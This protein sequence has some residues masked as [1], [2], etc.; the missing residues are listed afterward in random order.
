MLF[1]YLLMAHLVSDYLL[2]PDNLVEWKN[3]SK[4]GLTIHAFIHFLFNTLVLYVYTG[5]LAVAA[6]ALLLAIF[7]YT[8]DLTKAIYDRKNGHHSFSYWADQLVHYVSL[9][10]VT[11]IAWRFDGVFAGR[12]IGTGNPFELMFFNPFI[13]S[14]FSLAIFITL[15]V[16]YSSGLYSKK[17]HRSFSMLDK[18]NMIKR[19]L[20]VTIVYVGLL[21]ALVPSVGL[22]F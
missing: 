19:L 11:L 4:W 5:R 10:V 18:K 20:L 14:Y 9:L 1:L 22:N 15:T 3:Q 7:H 2:Q 12:T 16:E 21:F 17:K 13:I 6:L 8:I